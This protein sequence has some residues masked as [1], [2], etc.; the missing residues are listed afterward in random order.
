[1][2]DYWGADQESIF[3]YFSGSK[4]FHIGVH[5]GV[6]G[7][8]EPSEQLPDVLYRLQSAIVAQAKLKDAEVVDYSVGRRLSLLRLP[9]TRHSGSGLYKV[10]LTLHELMNE[11]PEHLRAMA[12]QP[13][14]S[15]FCDATGLIPLTDVKP[16]PDAADL[17]LGCVDE[18]KERQGRDLP[19]PESFLGSRSLTEALCDAELV[20]YYE[21]V[22]EGAR[23]WTTLRLASRM[24]CAGYPEDE[25]KQM[26]LNWNRRN[27]PPMEDREVARIVDVAYRAGVPYQFGCG[28]GQSDSPATA[29]VYRACPYRDR[30]KCSK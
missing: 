23:S 17:F 22:P 2:V 8:I 5:G 11:G 27:R 4:G 28:N 25:T 13:R 21:G 20:L 1:M 6:F 10:P 30:M 26:L 9:N 14:E 12:R 24:R 7:E 19:P 16:L 18:V 3:P 29:L 15:Y